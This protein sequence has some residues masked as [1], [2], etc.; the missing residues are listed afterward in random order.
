V[1]GKLLAKTTFEEHVMETYRLLGPERMSTIG[2]FQFMTLMTFRLFSR[3]TVTKED[4]DVL[5]LETG[6]GGRLDFTNALDRPLCTAITRLDYDHMDLLG[7]TITSIAG[8]KAGITKPGV[9]MFTSSSQVPEGL[10]VIRD[11]CQKLNSPL[12]LVPPFVDKGDGSLKVGI[13]GGAHQFENAALA[14]AMADYVFRAVK[15]QGE[16]VPRQVFEAGL[17]LCRFPGRAQI[18]KS[19]GNGMVFYLDGA[20]TPYSMECASRW[21]S[22]TVPGNEK[23]ALVFHCSPDRDAATMLQL[24]REMNPEIKLAF[25]VPPS[26]GINAGSKTYH[27]ELAALWNTFGDGR[28]GVCFR[29]G[30]I[31]FKKHLARLHS[32]EGLKH[33]CVTGSFYIVGD[34]LKYWVD[35]WNVD[36]AFS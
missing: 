24:F 2:F 15:P 36:E 35:G 33:V 3:T 9:Q 25:F 34:A 28:Q 18:E 11:V 17:E 4:I 1:N 6:I 12:Q 5:I 22:Q 23:A 29:S 7:S 30:P 31:E 8:E 10:V 27:D 19:A 32:E 13:G 26:T 14:W 16:T 21:L 20:H